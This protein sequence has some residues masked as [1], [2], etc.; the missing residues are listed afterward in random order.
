MPGGL[1]LRALAPNA[2]TS[3]ALCCGL[4]GIRFAIQG[5]WEKSVLAVILA[6]VLDGID[7]RIARLLKAQSRFGAELDSLADAISFG[8]APALIVFLWSLKD[9]PRLGWFAALAFAI[10]MALRLARFNAR[11]DLPDEPRKQAGFLTGVPAPVGAGLAFLPI[12]L[13][14]ASGGEASGDPIFRDPRIVGVWLAFNAFLLIS[15]IPTLSWKSLRPRRSVRLE[16]IA[17]F[18]IVFA[19]LLSEPWFTLVGICVVYLM[20]IP[21]GLV[22]Y[23]RVRRPRGAKAYEVRGEAGE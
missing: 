12:Y 11:I 16:L 15:A 23:M 3:A 1:T 10:C 2:I 20:L 19:A 6:G 4:T 14:I 9:V 18:G 22:M 21:V 5:E 8:V 17:L 13:W 7:G